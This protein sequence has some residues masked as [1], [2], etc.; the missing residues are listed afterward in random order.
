MTRPSAR[1]AATPVSARDTTQ[2]KFAA[3]D[4]A[5]PEYVD[6]WPKD[7]GSSW[8]SI[9]YSPT[10]RLYVGDPCV[11]GPRERQLMTATRGAVG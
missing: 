4:G 1:R 11:G 6:S 10:Q 9:A 8:V 5:G 7:D 2:S 3:A